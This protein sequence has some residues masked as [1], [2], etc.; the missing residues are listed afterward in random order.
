VG[1][2]IEDDPQGREAPD[3]SKGD[4]APGLQAIGHHLADSSV[5]LEVLNEADSVASDEVSAA[6]APILRELVAHVRWYQCGV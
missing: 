6:L 1:R 4:L 2:P 3:V 5:L